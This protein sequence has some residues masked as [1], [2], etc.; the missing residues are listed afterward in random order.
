MK[1]YPIRFVMATESKGEA[2]CSCMHMEPDVCCINELLTSYCLGLSLCLDPC[3]EASVGQ[4][5]S[6]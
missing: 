2:D 1:L 5:S 6:Q 4:G 3:T